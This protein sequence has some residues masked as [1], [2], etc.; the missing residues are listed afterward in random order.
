MKLTNG[1]TRL[2]PY[3]IGLQKRPLVMERKLVLNFVMVSELPLPER[4]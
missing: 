4:F 3:A 1:N 2:R